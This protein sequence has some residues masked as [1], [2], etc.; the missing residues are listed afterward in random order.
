V[1]KFSDLVKRNF[2]MAKNMFFLINYSFFLFFWIFLVVTFLLWVLECSQ[3]CEGNLYLFI[4]LFILKFHI[5]F[6]A[7][8]G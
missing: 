1:A 5:L 6:I 4:Y 7:K 2:R 3:K 8:F